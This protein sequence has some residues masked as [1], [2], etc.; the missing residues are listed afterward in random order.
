MV[1]DLFNR[2]CGI[3]FGVYNCL[4]L[5]FLVM[6]GVDENLVLNEIEDVINIVDGW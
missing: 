5:F 1:Y 2:F 4:D 6:C 3:I